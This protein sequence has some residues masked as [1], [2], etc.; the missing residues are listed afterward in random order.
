MSI[1][2]LGGQKNKRKGSQKKED[3]GSHRRGREGKWEGGL[4]KGGKGVSWGLG[5]ASPVEGLFSVKK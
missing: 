1:F 4:R 5:G 2:L 3:G